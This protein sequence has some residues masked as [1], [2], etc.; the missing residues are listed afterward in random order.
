MTILDKLLSLIKEYSVN[1]IKIEGWCIAKNKISI[2]LCELD[3]I[4]LQKI[5]L[6]L[7]YINKNGQYLFED[8]ILI[9]NR[10]KIDLT[11]TGSN[12]AG[13]GRVIEEKGV[14]YF[15]YHNQ[16]N[17]KKYYRLNMYKETFRYEEDK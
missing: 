3:Y 9:C 16:N 6:K 10:H 12:M 5:D 8:M 4:L 2:P 11:I 1:N 14:V 7:E 17:N 13:H 15:K